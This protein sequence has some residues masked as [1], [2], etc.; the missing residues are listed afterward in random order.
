MYV[1]ACEQRWPYC[2]SVSDV[3]WERLPLCL[4]QD[5]G[6]QE[7]PGRLPGTFLRWTATFCDIWGCNRDG[8]YFLERGGGGG[9]GKGRGTGRRSREASVSSLDC[10]CCC[11]HHRDW[12]QTDK[13]S[14]GQ[15]GR[16]RKTGEK[17]RCIHTWTFVHNRPKGHNLKG[18]MSCFFVFFLYLIFIPE[19]K[20]FFAY[21]M[22]NRMEKYTEHKI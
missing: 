1:C 10:T 3:S 22:S 5:E 16:E 21:K 19:G 4:L 13:E 17:D 8:E 7:R 15:V 14:G 11:A 6:C 2:S 20:T 9:W 12:L 18:A